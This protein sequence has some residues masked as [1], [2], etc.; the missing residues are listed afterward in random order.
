MSQLLG[1]AGATA[2]SKRDEGREKAELGVAVSVRRVAF[3][4]WALGDWKSFLGT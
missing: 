2:L 4:L 1:W 3:P